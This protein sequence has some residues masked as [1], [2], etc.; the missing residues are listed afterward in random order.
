M[1]TRSL[2]VL[3]GE[4]SD[5]SR[6][7]NELEE[8]KKVVQ[9]LIKKSPDDLKNHRVY[10]AYIGKIQDLLKLKIQTGKIDPMQLLSETLQTVAVYLAENKEVSAAH[11]IGDHV[12]KI[13]EKVIQQ[14]WDYQE[15]EA[16]G[17]KR[18]QEIKLKKSSNPSIKGA[19]N[20]KKN[21]KKKL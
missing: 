8:N 13:E 12:E 1:T 20:K 19:I 15:L 17:Q 10:C 18:Q 2:K 16:K 6:L 21:T 9:K 4:L 7:I 3:N 11:L 14:W 5:L